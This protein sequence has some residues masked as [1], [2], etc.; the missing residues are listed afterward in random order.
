VQAFFTLYGVDLPFIDP[1]DLPNQPIEQVTLVDTQ[2]PVTLKGMNPQT[3]FRVIDHHPVRSDLP[4][5]WHVISEEIG[6]TATIFVE[7]LNEKGSLLSAVQATLLLLG[8]YEDTGSL[9]YT[10][11]TARDIRAAAYLVEQGALLGVAS[12]FLNHPLSLKQQDLYDHLRSTAQTHLINGHTLIVAD[13]NAQHLDEEL[14]T[15][16]HKLRDLLDPDCLILL[17]I[18]RAGIQLIA[19]ST[20]D[21]INVAQIAAHFGGGGHSRAAAALIK[22]QSLSAVQKELLQILPRHVRPAVTVAQIMSLGAQVLTPETPVEEAVQ[23]MRRYG[24]EGYPVVKDGKVVGLLTRRAVDRAISHNLNLTASSLMEAGEVVVHPEDSLEQLQRLMTDTGWGQIPVVSDGQVIGIVTRTDLL[25]TLHHPTHL[26][27]RQKM[28]DRLEKALPAARLALLKAVAAQARSQDA[29]LYI[30]GGFVRDLLLERPSLDFDLVV[31]G[32]AIVLAAALANQYGGRVTGHSRFGTAKWSIS[33]VR[34]QLSH[35][36]EREQTA[37]PLPASPGE[38]SAND[39]P[40]TLDFITAR[41]EFYAHPTALPTVERGSIKLDLHRRDFT[42]NTL[43]MRLDGLHYGEL[44]DYWGGL[45]DLRQGIVR[46]LHSLSFVDDP[47]RML[48]AVRFEQRFGFEIEARTLQ[49]LHEA[50]SLLD[51]VSGDRIRH[52]L[53]HILEEEQACLMMARL[54][55]LNLLRSIHP[56][57]G[58]DDWLQQRT[59]FLLKIDLQEEWEQWKQ[60]QA[61]EAEPAPPQPLLLRRQLFY[62]LWLVRLP[63]SRAEE[64]IKRLKFSKSMADNILASC[65]LWQDLPKLVTE[66]PSIIVERLDEVPELALYTVFLASSESAERE[67]LLKYV[68]KWRQVAPFTTG[69]HLL[70]KGLPRGPEFRTILSALRAAWLDGE[71][72]SHEEE[73]ALLEEILAKLP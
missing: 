27:N 16:A 42:M 32:D 8:I 29:A 45:N 39:L 62:L 41:T 40:D 12:G 50:L 23:R 26:P 22:D 11:T 54:D 59:T 3:R 25:K 52:E 1:R 73:A 71:I 36:L 55:A 13:G 64:V 28:A 48:R 72:E 4:E 37:G 10:R 31:E 19:R 14:S 70:Q 43:A 30:V 44:H 66:K 6:A 46:C 7:A 60:P 35:A 57:L 51:R 53:D 67:I 38:L 9:T 65:S 47:T 2:S 5:G 63:A 58:W 68:Q 17:I 24:Y 69:Y 20:S 61:P 21:N 18:T 49:L 56:A 15:I 33:E 34:E